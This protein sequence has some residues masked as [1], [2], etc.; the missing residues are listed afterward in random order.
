MKGIIAAG[1]KG[2]RLYPLTLNISKHLLPVYNKPLIYYP[3]TNLIASGINEIC[4]VSTSL[5]IKKYKNHF[6]SGERLGCKFKYAV[7]EKSLGIPDVI[8]KAF[9]V[10]GETPI[11]LMLGDNIVTASDNLI[12]ILKKKKISGSQI[13]TTKVNDPSRFG[14]IN[15]DKSMNVLSLE[16]KPK[17]TKS[18]YAI[19]GLYVFDQE[20]YKYLNNI[21]IS[22]RG[23]YEIIDIINQYKINRSLKVNILKRGSVWFDAGTYDSMNRASNYIEL[24]EKQSGVMIGCIE[25]AAFQSG[26]IN[27][28]TLNELTKSMPESGYKNYLI[29]FQKNL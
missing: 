16:E 14:V 11:T 19:I 4:I 12:N 13:F 10:F 8:S 26:F 7:Q 25:E 21:N 6:G 17:S 22:K 18:N 23:E 5:D 3:L 9:E 27:K 1:G 15:F 28:E 2:T 20:V 29:D 24:S